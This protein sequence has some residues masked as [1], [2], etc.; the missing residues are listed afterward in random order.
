MSGASTL[1]GL[2][3]IIGGLFILVDTFLIWSTP[4]LGPV[5]TLIINLGISGCGLIGGVFGMKMQRG[6]GFL[7][8]IVG[9]LSIIFGIVFYATSWTTGMIFVQFSLVSDVMGIG[10]LPINLFLGVSLEAILISVGGVLAIVGA[11]KE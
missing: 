9:L 2:L 4:Y 11:G 8:L 1:G 10:S 6:A 7:A 5:Q 3:A